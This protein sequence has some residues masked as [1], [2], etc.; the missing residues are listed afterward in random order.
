MFAGVVDACF[1]VCFLAAPPEHER[2]ADGRFIPYQKDDRIATNRNGALRPRSMT[3]DALH[4]RSA[5]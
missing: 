2:P 5:L 4:T 1:M 3:F